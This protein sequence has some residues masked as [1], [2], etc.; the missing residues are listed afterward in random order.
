[1][2]RPSVG[3]VQ[4]SASNGSGAAILDGHVVVT[5]KIETDAELDNIIEWIVDSFHYCRF[6]PNA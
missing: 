4:H 6:E 1:M 2:T 3:S 5:S